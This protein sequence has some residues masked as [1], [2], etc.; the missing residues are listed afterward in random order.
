MSF[1]DKENG[2]QYKFYGSGL[3]NEQM[4]FSYFFLMWR[5]NVQSFNLALSPHVHSHQN[6]CH[7][8]DNKRDELIISERGSESCRCLTNREGQMADSWKTNFTFGHLS[9]SP[10]NGGDEKKLQ[11]TRTIVLKLNRIFFSIYK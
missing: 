5:N 9:I 10:P 6:R 2:T 8:F 1:L 11:I 4:D 7:T 3:I